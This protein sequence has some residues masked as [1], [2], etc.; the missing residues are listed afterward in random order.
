MHTSTQIIRTSLT[1]GAQTTFGHLY[2]THHARGVKMKIS[3][4]KKNTSRARREEEGLHKRCGVL[5]M[6]GADT[7]GLYSWDHICPLRLTRLI[8]LIIVTRSIASTFDDC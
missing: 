6:L 2:R 4:G 7:I 5:D 3:R 1:L 8:G